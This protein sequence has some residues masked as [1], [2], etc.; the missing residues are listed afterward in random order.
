MCI[1]TSRTARASHVYADATTALHTLNQKHAQYAESIDHFKFEQF[2]TTAVL[3]CEL[4]RVCKSRKCELI[5]AHLL[6]RLNASYYAKALM[7]VN[8]KRKRRCMLSEK[9]NCIRKIWGQT[10][11]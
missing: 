2:A 6:V 1:H 11:Q 3:C 7:S 8:K 10:E 4:T 9:A 5:C